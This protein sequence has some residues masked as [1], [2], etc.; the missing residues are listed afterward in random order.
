[1]VHPNRDAI[2]CFFFFSYG[3]GL[4]TDKRVD[5][6]NTRSRLPALLWFLVHNLLPKVSVKKSMSRSHMH[7][8]SFKCLVCGFTSL[9][10]NRPLFFVYLFPIIKMTKS[11][12]QPKHLIEPLMYQERAS[13]SNQ[14]DLGQSFHLSLSPCP[15]LSVRAAFASS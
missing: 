5:L 14:S 6:Q 12:N 3:V 15:A 2:G 1:M 8:Q 9:E 11:Y 7:G 4:W 10:S 13:L